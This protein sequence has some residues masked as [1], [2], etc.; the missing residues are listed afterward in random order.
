MSLPRMTAPKRAEI[1][2]PFRFLGALAIVSQ[3]FACGGSNTIIE[4]P[5]RFG[6]SIVPASFRNIWAI[7][8]D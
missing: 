3:G 7:A 8:R 4:T 1:T 6:S 2:G 5:A